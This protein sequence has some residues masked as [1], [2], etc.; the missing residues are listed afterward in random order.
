[1]LRRRTPARLPRLLRALLVVLFL[2]GCGVVAWQALPLLEER[3]VLR[4]RCRVRTSEGEAA[5][6]PEQ[7]ANAATIAAVGRRRGVG[8]RGVVIGLATAIQESKLRN[9]AVGDRDSVGLFQQRPSQGWGTREQILDPVYAAGRFYEALEEVPS[10]ERLPV[11]V[12]A[13]RVQRSAYGELYA[14]H[15][16]T[17]AVLAAALT[18]RV[19]GALGCAV[20]LGDAPAQTAGPDGLTP[21]AEELRAQLRAVFGDVR[22]GGF[23]PGGVRSG[24]VEGSAHYDGRAIDVLFRP[25]DDRRRREG[26]TLAHWLVAH[27]D[28]LHLA[29]VIYDGRIWSARR[30]AAG[31]RPYE[32]P[33]GPS[34]DP[35]LQHRDHVHVEVAE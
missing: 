23:A 25:V 32:H 33:D 4:E 21:R 14:Q 20:R 15:E 35:V 12:A 8:E 10:Y 18:G 22:L 9:L 16:G 31:W 2:A 24:H 29:T 17:A 13:Q 30:S 19:P 26:W 1:M 11:T 27:A 28:R 6:S 3:L 7:M 34:E 5:L